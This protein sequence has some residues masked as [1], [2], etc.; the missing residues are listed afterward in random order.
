MSE[1][2]ICMVCGYI[3]RGAAPPNRCPSCGAPFTAFQRRER[4]PKAKFRRIPIVE[5]RAPRFR[6]VIIGN[7]SAGRAAAFALQALDPDGSI[8]I[9][10][11]E[12]VDLYARPMLPDFLGGTDRRDLFGVGDTYPARGLE[13]VLGDAAVSLDPAARKVLCASGREVPYD[14]LLLAT[15]SAP[16]QV[17]WPGADC[18]GIGYFRTF[19]DADRLL[20]W[21]QSAHHAVVVGGGLLG[22]EFVRAFHL[23]GLPATQ[24][25]R[26]T[27]VGFPALDEAAGAILEKALRE[28]GVE[29]ALD[30]EV[31]SFESSDGRVCAVNTTRGRRIECDLVG[32]A[33]GARPRVE[34]AQQAGLTVDRGVVVN[35]RFQTSDPAI[36]AAGDVAQAWDQVWGEQRVNTSWRNAR[37][38]GEFAGVCMAGGE[39][40]YPGAVAANFQL[41]AGLPFCALGI[42]SPPDPENYQIEAT[43]DEQALTCRKLVRV[44]GVLVGACLIGSLDEAADLEAE[45]RESDKSALPR[46][47]ARSDRAPAPAPEAQPGAEEGPPEEESTMHEMTKQNLEA[48]FAGESQAH[49][50]YLNFAV[51]ADEDGKQNTAR[52]FRAASFAEQVHATRHVE[53]LEGIGG[54]SENLDEAAGGEGFEVDEMYPA[55]MAVADAQ[56]EDDAYRSFD[57]AYQVEQQ[58]LALYQKAK[59][60]VAAGQDADLG[61]LQVCSYCGCTLE[62]E[63]PDKCP[64]CGGPKSGF[65]AF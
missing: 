49:M 35:R 16:I 32:V 60:A 48:A 15:G 43:A 11:E 9:L 51:K 61:P 64:V 33:V 59:A 55:Y 25:I 45:I 24:L 7:S 52:L 10:S 65:V 30:E 27:V 5:E 4:D 20:Q 37:E 14:A 13:L 1:R 17:P 3:H 29:V 40:E 12:Q 18:E 44:N 6:Y 28:W 2:W 57:Y 46:P 38:Q 41:A 31:E 58:H 26:G 34:L 22:L 62:G 54:T 56:E 39:G 19:A 21:A 8:T 47:S 50:K 63:A 23:R 53:V 42:S 36:Y